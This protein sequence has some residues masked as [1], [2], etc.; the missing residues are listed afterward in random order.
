MIRAFVSIHYQ[1]VAD[2]RTDGFALTISRS[3]CTDMLT[4]DIKKRLFRAIRTPMEKN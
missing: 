4:R 1:S 3:A 2:R